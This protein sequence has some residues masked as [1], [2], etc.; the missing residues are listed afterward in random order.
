MIQLGANSVL[1]GGHSLED[2]FRVLK[3]SGYDGIEISAI[4][5]MSQ[6]FVISDWRNYATTLK[7]C[8]AKY[9]LPILAMEQPNSALDVMELSFQAAIE[10]GIPIIN[11]GPGGKSD[12][13][14]S[15]ESRIKHF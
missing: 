11:V 5:G 13:P 8:V 12:D 1:F 3:K 7:Q 6:H 4:P 14:G 10:C 15:L 2:A 9:A